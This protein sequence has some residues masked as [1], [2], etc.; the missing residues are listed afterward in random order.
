MQDRYYSRLGGMYERLKILK[1]RWKGWKI[2]ETQGQMER[3]N[4]QEF[5]HLGGSV[6]NWKYSRLVGM[7]GRLEMLKVRW[8]GCKIGITQGQVECMKD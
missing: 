2:R 1:V 4:D 7:D 8:Q 5:S 6:E 3:M